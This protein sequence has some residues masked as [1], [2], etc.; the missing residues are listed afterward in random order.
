MTDRSL[1]PA[2]QA[3][4]GIRALIRQRLAAPP[5]SSRRKN[6]KEFELRGVRPDEV[7]YKPAQSRISRDTS[8]AS[9]HHSTSRLFARR[10][11]SGALPRYADAMAPTVESKLKAIHRM[12]GQVAIKPCEASPLPR[13][14]SA[15]S[16]LYNNRSTSRASQQAREQQLEEA[17]KPRP[18]YTKE[19]MNSLSAP[20]GTSPTPYTP[21][22]ETVRSRSPQTATR[23]TATRRSASADSGSVAGVGSRSA[24]GTWRQLRGQQ[25]HG[26]A[27][28][29]PHAYGDLALPDNR[30]VRGAN[31][32]S[33]HTSAIDDVSRIV[34][35]PLAPTPSFD[36][37]TRPDVTPTRGTGGGLS[38]ST[39]LSPL[40]PHSTE[41]PSWAD[42]ASPEHHNH[43]TSSAAA[44]VEEY[45]RSPPIRSHSEPQDDTPPHRGVDASSRADAAAAARTRRELAEQRLATA[46]ASPPQFVGGSR[47]SSPTQTSPARA[48]RHGLELH[49]DPHAAGGGHAW[50]APQTFA[51]PRPIP[52]VMPKPSGARPDL[53]Q[54]FGTQNAAMAPRA[55]APR[56]HEPLSPQEHRRS[57][58][59][60]AGMQ[61]LQ[62]IAHSPPA[63]PTPVAR[64]ASVERPPR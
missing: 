43:H 8:V 61:L 47:Q 13:S 2:Q 9:V 52:H 22:R 48:G 57:T 35:P 15:S 3:R 25:S 10:D 41:K 50:A 60:E 39:E 19:R 23:V 24:L 12:A 55:A 64:P 33:A 21:Q 45:L 31:L 16:R 32:S 62:Q 56:P 4:D 58:I 44:R 42:A 36:A 17:R 7:V 6:P 49:H 29:R 1:D 28:L 20:R 14:Q 37:T 63:H 34:R 18:K 53:F 59:D 27:Q 54:G 30:P 11:T 38:N 40:S 26:G 46:Q 5:A 51:P